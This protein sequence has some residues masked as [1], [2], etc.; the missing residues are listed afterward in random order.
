MVA[1]AAAVAV[2]RARREAMQGMAVAGAVTQPM[3]V[4]WTAEVM[5]E[6]RAEGMAG[7]QAA[8]TVAMSARATHSH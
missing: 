4:A 3:V 2:V 1:R 7:E 6:V 8:Q 5:T